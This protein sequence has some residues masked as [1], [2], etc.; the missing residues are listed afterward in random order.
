MKAFEQVVQHLI[1]EV[2][3]VPVIPLSVTPVSVRN[4]CFEGE[5]E[6]DDE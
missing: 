2:P 3:A 6:S 1:G 5:D 4:L